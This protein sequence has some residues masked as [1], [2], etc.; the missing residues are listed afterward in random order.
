MV[1]TDVMMPIMNGRQ[2][3]MNIKSS[4]ETSHIPVILLTG[5]DS[6]E[7]IIQGLESGADDYIVKP[8]DFDVLKTKI[9]GFLKTRQVL[10]SKFNEATSYSNQWEEISCDRRRKGTCAGALLQTQRCV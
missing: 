8:F 4:V 3:C 9:S 7:H 1:L 6:K 2:L 5:Q 10:K